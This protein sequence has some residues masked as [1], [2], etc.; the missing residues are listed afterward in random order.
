MSLELD[1]TLFIDD[2]AP[3]P[4]AN[5]NQSRRWMATINN[6]TTDYINPPDWIK[7]FTAG[8]VWGRE[9]GEQGTPHIQ[10]FL[11]TKRR[12]TL[13]GIRRLFPPGFSM[14]LE[15]ARGNAKQCIDYCAKDGNY[16]SWGTLPKDGSVIAE[17]RSRSE[18][19]EQT[20]QYATEGLHSLISA[21][22]RIK[23]YTTLKL[24]EAD[25]RKR[26][27]DLEGP[28]GVWIYGESGYGK[29]HYARTEFDGD[30][31]VKDYSKWWGGYHGEP[32][33][34]LDDLAPE[35][36]YL[37]SQL[38]LWGDKYPFSGEVKGGHTGPI[39]PLRFIVTSQYPIEEIFMQDSKTVDAIRRRFRVIHIVRCRVPGHYDEHGVHLEAYHEGEALELS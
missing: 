31:Y 37:S 10:A 24:I 28:A 8:G 18:E 36:S 23:H 7:A 14:H 20:F 9:V 1:E 21:E 4:S 35:H 27:R 13:G 25:H 5:R 16:T 19:W 33:V 22:K 34:I 39:R 3:Q 29:S 6:Y 17:N 2:D 32:N 15:M 12:Y 38:K 11:W 26:P 30:F